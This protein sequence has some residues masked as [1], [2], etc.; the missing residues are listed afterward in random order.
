MLRWN[1]YVFYSDEYSAR[2]FRFQSPSGALPL[3][4]AGDFRPPDPSFVPLANSSLRPCIRYLMKFS[5]KMSRQRSTCTP[6][7]LL[8]TPLA[9]NTLNSVWSSWIST[10]YRTLHYFDYKVWSVLQQQVYK[11]KVNSVDEL[12]QRIQTVWDEL[13]QRIIDKAIKWRTRLRACVEA[14]GG[15]FEH[16]L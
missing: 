10:K 14:K 11:V 16:K 5:V 6:C 1:F 4:P 12:R 13:D 7:P 3:D 2:G 15:H 9:S 8:A